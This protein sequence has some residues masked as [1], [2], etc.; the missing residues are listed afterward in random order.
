M[1]ADSLSQLLHQGDLG[2]GAVMAGLA[3]AFA[4]GA[5]HALSPGHGKTVVAAYLVG[6]RGTARHA[7]FLGGMVTFTHTVSVF[8]LG[9]V[10]LFLSRYVLPERIYPVLGAVS[11]LSIVWIGAALLRRRWMSLRAHPHPHHHHHHEQ[12]HAHDRGH[13]DEHDHAHDHG[14]ADEHDHAHD[15]DH[16]HEHGHT[17]EHSHAHDHGHTHMPEG[18]VTL[19]SLAALGASGGLVP[20]PSALVLLLSSVALGRVA[21][22]LTLLVAF[23]A[24]LAMVLTAIGLAVVYARHLL[25]ERAFAHIR[26]FRLIPV[27]SAA[28]IVG[29]GLVM[30]AAALGLVPSVLRF[31]TGLDT[32]PAP[33]S[34]SAPAS[35]RRACGR[36][37]AMRL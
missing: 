1:R 9:F 22:G 19:G 37:A 18:E 14:H 21:L 27:L 4:L 35:A 23:S 28:V 25:P 2:A 33:P 13:A 32:P 20:C 36:A 12:D 15:H 29:V 3:L 7:A 34:P 8:L 31:T 24:G 6:T 30:T 10:T 17:H 11:G 16:T 5:V 26:A